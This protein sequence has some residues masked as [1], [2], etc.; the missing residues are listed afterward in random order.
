MTLPELID[1]YRDFVERVIGGLQQKAEEER[2]HGEEGR[3]PPRNRSDAGPRLVIGIDAIDQIDDVAAACAFLDELSSVFGIANCVYVI[4]V[5][6]DTL[7]AVD[8][9]AV[10]LKTSSGGLFDEMVWLEPLGLN[11][12]GEL[13]DRRVTGLPASFIALCYV[14]SGGLQRE[15]LR[16]AR[17]IF[18]APGAQPAATDGAAAAGEPDGVTLADAACHVID[19]EVQA[20]KQR[21]LASAVSLEISAA[22]ELLRLL[23]DRGWPASWWTAPA[24][25]PPPF[26][27][28]S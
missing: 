16:I 4:A 7:A 17:A 25:S 8:Q 27:R 14:L 21:T 19:S 9:R 26:S 13:L 24:G 18:A 10:P 28:P 15:L 23:T 11:E 6:P 3:M 22:P 2:Q 1:D 5:S 20:L 12:A